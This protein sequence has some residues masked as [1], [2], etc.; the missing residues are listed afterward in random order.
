MRA[1]AGEALSMVSSSK[2]RSSHTYRKEGNNAVAVKVVVD[3]GE[4]PNKTTDDVEDEGAVDDVF[5][6][7]MKVLQHP[8]VAVAILSDREII[9]LEG[10]ELLVSL[11]GAGG[12]VAKKL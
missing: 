11:E 7:I 6:E 8:L 3:V 2:R 10:A 9:L 1:M 5:A 12:T 4:A